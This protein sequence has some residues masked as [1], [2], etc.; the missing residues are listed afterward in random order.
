MAET[1]EKR[2]VSDNAQLMSVWDFDKNNASNISP[3]MVT[4]GSNKEVWWKCH[5]G[6][7][8]PKKIN[9]MHKN[10]SCPI[11]SGHKTVPGIN[12]F[13]TFYPEIAKEWHPTKNGDLLPSEIS[14][15]NGRTIWWMCE[16][17]HEWPATPKDRATDKTGC[18]ICKS[19][20]NTSFPEQAIYYYVKKLYPNAIN[21]Y[22]DIFDNGMEL[23]IY[24]PSINLG[25]EYDGGAWHNGEEAHL[26]EREKYEVCQRKNIFLIRVKERKTNWNDVADSIYYIPNRR[27]QKELSAIIQSILDSI[28]RASN[29]WTRKNPFQYHSEILVNLERDENEI[30]EYLTAIPNSLAELRPDLLDDWHYA[31]NGNLRPDM[32][33][34]N[35]NDYVWW[36]CKNCGHEWRT[37]IIHRAGKRNCGCKNCSKELRGKTFTKN[38]VAERGSLADNNPTLAKEWHPTKNGDLTPSDITEKRFK[39]VWWLCP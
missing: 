2:Y 24:I 17:G 39:N 37:T 1:T 8:F 4:V 27:N 5:K 33:G 22:K 29:M 14:K 23:D 16:Y 36:K 10:Y 20:R 38:K 18:P 7:S 21:R 15:K 12:D 34:I 11:C 30:R 13:A 31:K 19:R 28:D 25:I 6:H 35:S 26:K 9:M 32:F 3:D